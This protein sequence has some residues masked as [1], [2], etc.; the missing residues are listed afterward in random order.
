MKA[1]NRATR[2]RDGG[3]AIT[4]FALIAPVLVILIFG[5]V[6]MAR[7]YNA[8]VTIQ[9]AARE[10][11]RFGVT[12]KASC[13]DASD[14]IACIDAVTR[15]HTQSLTNAPTTIDV[16]VRSWD[17]PAYANPA[18]EGSAGTQCDALEVEVEYEY[19]PATPIIG[20]LIGGVTMTARERLVNE[21]FGPC[22]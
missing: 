3:Q 22:A 9:G 1:R 6:D 13:T 7:A 11:A 2:R 16:S 14:R 12:G 17:Y 10:G 18:S 5:I 4:E 8:W 19:E 21:P 20:H 15:D